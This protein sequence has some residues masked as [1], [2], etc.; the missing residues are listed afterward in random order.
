MVGDDLFADIEG[1]QSLNINTILVKTGKFREKI[2]NNSSIK[3][4]LLLESIGEINSLI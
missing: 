3:P 2:F 4:D 1:A